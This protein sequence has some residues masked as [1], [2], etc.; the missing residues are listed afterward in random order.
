MYSILC[1]FTVYIHDDVGEFLTPPTS[2]HD[3]G[4]DMPQRNLWCR[5]GHFKRIPAS[6]GDESDNQALTYIKAVA[7][8]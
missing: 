8:I 5:H 3:Q 7:D 2:R 4:V 1:H 6:D